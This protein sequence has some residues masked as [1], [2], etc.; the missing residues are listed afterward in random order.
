MRRAHVLGRRLISKRNLSTY[1]KIPDL[2]LILFVYQ[3]VRRL[4]VPVNDKLLVDKYHA[5]HNGLQHS[6]ILFL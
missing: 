3:Y 6:K 1:P 4:D 2:N 5:L